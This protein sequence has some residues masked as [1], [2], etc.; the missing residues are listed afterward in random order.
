MLSFSWPFVL[1]I[2]SVTIARRRPSTGVVGTRLIALQSA[3]RSTGI[4]NTR[5]PA[6]E[7]GSRPFKNQLTYFCQTTSFY[8]CL[9]TKLHAILT[10]HLGYKPPIMLFTI[11]MVLRSKQNIYLLLIHLRTILFCEIQFYKLTRQ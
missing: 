7:R 1:L 5:G 6:G 10:R 8:C 11:V 3:N 4:Q 9:S 2:H